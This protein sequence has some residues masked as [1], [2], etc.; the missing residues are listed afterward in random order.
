MKLSI[1]HIS[2]LHRDPENPIGNEALLD[3]LENDRRRYSGEEHPNIRLPDLIIVSGDIVQGVNPAAADPEKKLRAQYAEALTFLNKLTKRFLNGDK[4]RIVI[5]PGNHDI[6]ARDF[7]SCLKRIDLAPD[8]KKELVTQ[9]FSPNSLLRWSWL[10]FEL[11]EIADPSLY[12][13]RLA[14][15]CEF[16]K[17]FYE[18]GRTYSLD[19]SQQFDIFDF[20]DF[21]LTVTAFC[22]CHNNDI[23][24]KQGS[25]HPDC[26]ASAGMAL[27]ESNYDNRLRV[28]VWHHNTEGLPLQ[29][30][31]MDPDVLQNLIDRGFSLGFHGHQHR[32]QFLDTRFRHEGSRRITVISAG[33]LCGGASLRFGRAYNLVEL[34]TEPRKGYLHVRE[35]QNDNL[36]LPIWGRRPLPPNIGSCLEFVYD[37]RPEPMVPVDARTSA[38]VEAQKLYEKGEYRRAAVVLAPAATVDDLAR[39]LLFDSLVQLHD[40]PAIISNFDPPQSPAEAVHLMD[41]LWAVGSRG[42]LAQLLEESVVAESSDG[43]VIEIRNKYAAR[44]KT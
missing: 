2:D 33:T 18:G 32:P 11:Y 3:S 15:F 23:F 17:D 25:I 26:I 34:D 20:P 4:K 28:A 43:S 29:V 21:E 10:D 30:D 8:R 7:I 36:V 1:L 5:V 12:A 22:S 37:A 39:R 9:L 35:M 40:D 14:A 41:A 24:N 31:Y 44:L 13:A 19:P 16:Y 6:S 42:R 27:R 38:L